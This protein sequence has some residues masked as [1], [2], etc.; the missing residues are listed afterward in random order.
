MLGN[1]N[2]RSF[3]LL[4]VTNR[5]SVGRIPKCNRLLRLP[6]HSYSK[7]N[8]DFPV[9]GEAKTTPIFEQSVIATDLGLHNM[10]LQ[11]YVDATD[12]TKNDFYLWLWLPS[13]FSQLI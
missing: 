12:S 9:I 1:L 5:T 10:L 7:I 4:M 3:D 13:C 11:Q 6:L 2:I 8:S